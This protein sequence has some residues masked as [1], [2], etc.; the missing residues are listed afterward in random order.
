MLKPCRRSKLSL[1]SSN[2][3]DGPSYN[4]TWRFFIYIFVAYFFF[5]SK[6][7][8]ICRKVAIFWLH[9]Y[10]ST[11]DKVYFTSN[12]WTRLHVKLCFSNIIY[13]NVLKLYY[14]VQHSSVKCDTLSRQHAQISVLSAA[15]ISKMWYIFRV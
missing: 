15:L 5:I 1:F 12:L 7:T 3:W 11:P 8:G 4:V 10:F 2:G 6:W 9:R 14:R 13:D